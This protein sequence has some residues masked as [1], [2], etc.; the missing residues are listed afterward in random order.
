MLASRIPSVAVDFDGPIHAYR[1]GWQDG[2][3]YDDP[4]PG[5]AEAIRKLSER[6]KVIIF[7]SRADSQD[8]MSA[9]GEWMTGHEMDGWSTIT[10]RKLPWEF[11]IDDRVIRWESWSQAWDTIHDLRAQGKL[12]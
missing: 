10:N 7:S 6:Y 3:I 12:K 2:S 5:A 8:K 9:M 11:L 4:T 1:Q